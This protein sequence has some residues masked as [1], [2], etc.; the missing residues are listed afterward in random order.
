[1][2]NTHPL[3]KK[4]STRLQLTPPLL[5]SL[6]TVAVSCCVPPDGTA[7]EVGAMETVIPL[8]V[9]AADAV[10]AGSVTEA[11]VSVTVRFPAGT[12]AV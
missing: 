9:M 3:S 11:A 12:G 6:A 7:A 8:T 2:K 10:T 5:G 1:M 4:P